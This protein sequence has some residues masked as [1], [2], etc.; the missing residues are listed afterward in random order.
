[1]ITDDI[2]IELRRRGVIA[3][4]EVLKKEG[5]L[6]YALNVLTQERRIIKNN[7]VIGEVLSSRNSGFQK[8]IL[9]G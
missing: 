9:K 2:Q 5:D 4:N 1:M 6:Y 3:A 7:H 8:K